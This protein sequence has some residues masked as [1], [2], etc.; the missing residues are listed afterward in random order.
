MVD[1]SCIQYT[2]MSSKKWSTVLEQKRIHM[3]CDAIRMEEDYAVHSMILN[4]SDEDE[5]CLE[6]YNESEQEHNSDEDMSL[7]SL[8]LSS[9]LSSS[10]SSSS[11]SST[12]SSISN[13]L[14]A[15]E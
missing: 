9:S 14:I 12:L 3:I 8:S 15:D 1:C 4:L 7:S 2:N 10:S 6:S 13:V 11:S 5:S